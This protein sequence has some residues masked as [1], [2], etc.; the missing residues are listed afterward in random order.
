MDKDKTR[1]I[2]L[3]FFQA[4][5]EGNSEKVLEEYYHPNINYWIP[6]SSVISGF[7]NLE[8]L[9]SVGFE[10]L[11]AFPRGLQI[12]VETILVDGNMASVTAKGKAEFSDGVPYE[13]E[14]HYFLRFEGEKIIEVR[15]YMDTQK[16]F[17]MVQHANKIKK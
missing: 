14:Y 3:G 13:N 5:N 12:E 4:V 7:H 8:S 16:S 17:E 1:E 2:V 6:G 10:L 15:E 11:K 9:G